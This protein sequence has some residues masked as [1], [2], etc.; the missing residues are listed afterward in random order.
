MR[1]A[2]QENEYD[3]HENHRQVVIHHATAAAAAVRVSAV[4]R[5]SAYGEGGCAHMR[6]SVTLIAAAAESLG[7][8]DRYVGLFAAVNHGGGGP[9]DSVSAAAAAPFVAAL[10]R[11]S[12]RL[13]LRPHPLPADGAQV[14]PDAPASFPARRRS[15]P[16]PSLR[17]LR[18]LVIP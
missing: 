10:H 15:G 14:L 7:H 18:H 1:F 3:P 2:S 12:A 8:Q 5:L 9:S 16:K 11:R 13:H 17:R 6:F 4:P